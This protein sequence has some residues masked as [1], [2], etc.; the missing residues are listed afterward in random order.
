MSEILVCRNLG[1]KFGEFVAVREISFHIDEGEI[2]GLLGPNG[3]GK[4]TTI[5]M[6]TCLYPPPAGRSRSSDMM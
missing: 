2:F 5:S 4:S 3:A 1:K 6:L